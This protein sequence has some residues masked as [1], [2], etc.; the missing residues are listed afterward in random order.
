MLDLFDTPV[1]PGLSLRSDILSPAEE[2]MLIERIDAIDLT[3]FRFQGWTG[4]RLPS[5]FG[6]SYDFEAGRPM[7]A[8][9]VPDWLLPIRERVADFAGLEPAALVQ[10]LLIGT[11]RAPA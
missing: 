5:S 1:L 2:M 6:W 3:P 9:P 4:K 10:A 7:L 8:P 11:M